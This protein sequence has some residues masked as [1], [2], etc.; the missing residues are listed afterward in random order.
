MK[1]VMRTHPGKVRPSNQDAAYVSE[2]GFRLYAVADGMGG[3]RGGDVASAMAIEGLAQLQNAEPGEQAIRTCFSAINQAIHDRQE[4]EEALQGMGT[5]LT[6]LWETDDSMLLGHVG[7]SRAY[8]YR[9]GRLYQV[10]RD[11]SLVG[12]LLRTGVIDK[13]AAREYPYRHIIT[14]AV[15]TD[16]RLACDTAVMD[17]LAGDRWLLCSD[18]LTDHVMDEEIQRCLALEDMDAGADELMELALD[19]GGQDNITLVLLEVS[20]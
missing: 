13:E 18:G 17:K 11:H 6:L 1:A 12:E 19:A 4:A 8:L 3:H 14:R 7:D 20:V 10:S 15:G 2:Q 9:Q 16:S 5:T